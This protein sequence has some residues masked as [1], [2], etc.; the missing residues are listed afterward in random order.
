LP[1]KERQECVVPES[2]SPRA[3]FER[4]VDGISHRRWHELPELYAEDAVIDYPF[5]VARVRLDGRDAIRRYFAVVARMPLD[6]RAHNTVDATGRL[7]ELLTAL[8]REQRS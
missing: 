6:L 3:V 4:L 5:A 7:P 2:E 8:D 1:D